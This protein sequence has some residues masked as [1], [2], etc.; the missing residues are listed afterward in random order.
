MPCMKSVFLKFHQY[1]HEQ[2]L[3]EVANVPM[4]KFL[5]PLFNAP[6]LNPLCKY[7]HT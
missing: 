2:F 6:Y 4:Q 3:H 5:F 7:A 1:D